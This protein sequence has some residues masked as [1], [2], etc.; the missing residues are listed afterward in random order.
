ME[1]EMTRISEKGQVVIPN[2]LRQEMGIEASDQ[3]LVFGEGST[4]I[5][6]RIEKPALQ[7]SLSEL[8]KPLQ[9]IVAEVGF[10]RA[11]LAKAIKGLRKQNA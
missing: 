9:K 1:V 8:T 3:F 2:S 10:T 6:K 7:R 11:E 4:I 5:L